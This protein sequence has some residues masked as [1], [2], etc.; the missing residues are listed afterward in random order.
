M[1]FLR[2]ALLNLP[3]TNIFSIGKTKNDFFSSIVAVVNIVCTTLVVFLELRSGIYGVFTMVNS[4]S[5]TLSTPD[6]SFRNTPRVIQTMLTTADPNFRS[7]DIQR[8]LEVEVHRFD[9]E[10][11][12]NKENIEDIII[13]DAEL[14]DDILNILKEDPSSTK[15]SEKTNESLTIR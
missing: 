12:D 11:F 8:P 6:C 3:F 5:T 13:I 15:S 9:R 2:S 4:R 14:D 1:N 7:R 10:N